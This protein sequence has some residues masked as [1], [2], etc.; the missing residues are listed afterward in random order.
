MH[1][2]CAIR[3]SQGP[4]GRSSSNV[5]SLRYAWNS[6]ADVPVQG[7]LMAAL[8]DAGPRVSRLQ[9]VNQELDVS[10]RRFPE[11][12]KY[13]PHLPEALRELVLGNPGGQ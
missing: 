5:S 7:R 1:R 3:N 6:G 11:R 13:D 8:G 4:R 2:L 10:A 9:E 12:L